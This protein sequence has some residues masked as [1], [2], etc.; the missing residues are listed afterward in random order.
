MIGFARLCPGDVYEI[1]IKY[2]SN[3]K[4]RARTKIAKDGTQTWDLTNFSLKITI[5]DLLL[6]KV[7]LFAIYV[8]LLFGTFSTMKLCVVP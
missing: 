2:G 1:Q 4:F 7:F 8:R 5:H 6:I 3:S